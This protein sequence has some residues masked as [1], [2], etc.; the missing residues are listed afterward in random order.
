[1][2]KSKRAIIGIQGLSL[3]DEE[4]FILKKYSPLGIILFSRNI[5]NKK[6]VKKLIINIRDSLGWKCPILI[7]QE[8]GRVQRLKRPIWTKYPSA[9][10]FG[11]IA[12]IS[13]RKAKRAVYLN[14]VLLGIEL[15]ELGISVNCA[16]C[17]D[18]KSKIMHSI[19]GDRSFSAN[20]NIVTSLGDSACKGM[21]DAGILPVIKHIPG[22]GKAIVDSHKELPK[23]TDSIKSLEN[24]DFIPFKALSKMP[25]AM[26][27]HILFSNIDKNFPITQSKKAYNYI[28]NII[29]YEGIL[30]SDDID[31]LAL[32]GSIKYKVDSII[33][34]NFDIVLH[35][36]GNIIDAEQVLIHTPLLNNNLSNQWKVHLGTIENSFKT[37]NKEIYKE[38]INKIFYDVLKINSDYY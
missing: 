32:S 3:S 21:I 38:K 28:R 13:L 12:N 16:P 10:I 11:D 7:D 34:A 33:K 30:I 14:Y 9:K 15:K 27:A 4:I 20:P 18:V 35:C 23:I 19:I 5:K 1:M 26:T 8:G 25:I 36:S 17:L 6:Q 22:H 29:K 37:I 2:K 31:M 24:S